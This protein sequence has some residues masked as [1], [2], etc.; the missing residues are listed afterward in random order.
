MQ[1]HCKSWAWQTLTKLNLAFTTYFVFPKSSL[2]KLCLILIE[3]MRVTGTEERRLCFFSKLCLLHGLTCSN[4]E[5]GCPNSRHTVWSDVSK[6][7]SILLDTIDM[8]KGDEKPCKEY[9]S[10]QSGSVESCLDAYAVPTLH[11]K[12]FH[13]LPSCGATTFVCSEAGGTAFICCQHS[14]DRYISLRLHHSVSPSTPP[15]FV[16]RKCQH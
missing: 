12:S 15:A 3:L 1:L 8:G 4:L 11:C 6:F 13:L 16:T 2:F 5:T 7:L 9:T 14:V 10:E